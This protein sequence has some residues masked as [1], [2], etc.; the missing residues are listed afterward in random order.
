MVLV[1]IKHVLAKFQIYLNRVMRI[2]TPQIRNPRYIEHSQ[3]SLLQQRIV[4]YM[5]GL[6]R[7]KTYTRIGQESISFD[8][9]MMNLVADERCAYRYT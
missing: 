6:R 7:F 9:V 5:P 3:L 4:W 1:S 8:K 2:A